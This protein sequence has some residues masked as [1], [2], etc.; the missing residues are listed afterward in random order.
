MPRVAVAAVGRR[1]SP[2]THDAD[3]VALALPPTADR[4]R[5]AQVADLARSGGREPE[6]AMQL[7]AVGGR[8]VGHLARQG[9]APDA[10]RD[11]AGVLTGDADDMAAALLELR[12]RTG[13]SYITVAAEHSDL[14]APVMDVI[15]AR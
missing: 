8:L 12:A 15:T 10:L 2:P 1:S 4:G 9:L 11:A 13:V 14:F 5:V 6:L 7:S 3:T